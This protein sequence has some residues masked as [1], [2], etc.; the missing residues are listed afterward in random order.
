MRQVHQK[1]KDDGFRACVASL[2]EYPIEAVPH[3]GM[4]PSWIARTAVESFL[5]TN[6]YKMGETMRIDKLEGGVDGCWIMLNRK[7]G[8]SR[9]VIINQDAVV[10]HDPMVGGDFLDVQCSGEIYAENIERREDAEWF[11]FQNGKKSKAWPKEETTC[12]RLMLKAVFTCLDL[13]SATGCDAAKIAL[14]TY[15]GVNENAE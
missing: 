12:N 14:M 8:K 10:V 6:G 3:F 2:L 5:W 4:L 11:Q 1:F 15:F 13:R 7:N 9:P